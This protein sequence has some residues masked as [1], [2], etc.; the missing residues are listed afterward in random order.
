MQEM[1]HP[2]AVPAVGK[3]GDVRF[4]R[5]FTRIDCAGALLKLGSLF[6]FA[7]QVL[8]FDCRLDHTAAPN[9]SDGVRTFVQV[10]YGAAW[11]ADVS[12][13]PQSNLLNLV[14]FP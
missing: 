14:C 4:D 2:Q 12:S 9:D 3:A 13:P 5:R 11:Y 10:R 7:V 6:R 1:L 8:I